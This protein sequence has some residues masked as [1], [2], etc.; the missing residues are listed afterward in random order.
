MNQQALEAKKAAVAAVVDGLKNSE[1]VT[2][3]SYQGLTVSEF[4]ELRRTLAKENACIGVYKNTLVR[5]ALKEAGDADL[6][7][8]LNGPNAF[9]F[10]KELSNGPKVLVKFARCHQKL[11]VKGGL[12]EGKVLNADDVKVISKLPNHDG[13]ISMLLSCLQAPITKF[14][15]TVKAIADKSAEAPAPAAN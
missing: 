14:A 9:V 4:Q 7:E 15:A 11:V 5:R 1:S 6:G 13:M 2:V 3:V 8:I 12:A 10:S